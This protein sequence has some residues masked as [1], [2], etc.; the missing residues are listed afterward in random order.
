M[1]IPDILFICVYIY[2]FFTHLS[3]DGHLDCFHILAIVNSAV[4]NIAGGGCIYIF[5][6]SFCPYIFPGMGLLDHV[7]V[8]FFNFLRLLH[9]VF[10]CDCTNLHALNSVAGF[11]F[12]H[13]LTNTLFCATVFLSGLLPFSPLGKVLA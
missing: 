6:L 4:M 3:V 5:E 13:L 1:N 9:T 7:V 12:L 8:I 2:I 10:H 11:A